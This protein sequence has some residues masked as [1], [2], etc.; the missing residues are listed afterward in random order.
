MNEYK[1][2]LSRNIL[3]DFYKDKKNCLNDHK[4]RHV[5]IRYKK[6]KNEEK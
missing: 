1:I 5:I 6:S 2:K 3:K 4:I